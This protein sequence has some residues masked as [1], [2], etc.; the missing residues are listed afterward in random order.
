[1]KQNTHSPS[2]AEV[3]NSRAV[4]FLP[5]TF[6]IT[7]FEDFPTIRNSKKLENTF[8]KLDLFPSSGEERETPTPLGLL[9]DTLYF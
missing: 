1:V 4:P 5:L 8:R 7:R 2:S 9:R 3:K 6:R